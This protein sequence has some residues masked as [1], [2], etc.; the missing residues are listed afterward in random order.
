MKGTNL[1]WVLSATWGHTI[2]CYLLSIFHLI[3]I[4]TKIS[5]LLCSPLLCFAL[6]FPPHP[7]TIPFLSQGSS[8]FLSPP[9]AFSSLSSLSL[10]LSLLPFD[11]ADCNHVWGFFY[12]FFF[13]NFSSDSSYLGFCLLFNYLYH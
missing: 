8:L 1:V 4:N 3:K 11:F 12:F 2:G 13:V 10:S 5:A 6:S 9:P 7:H